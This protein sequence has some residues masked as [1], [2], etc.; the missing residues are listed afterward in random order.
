MHALCSKRDRFFGKKIL[1]KRR[2]FFTNKRLTAFSDATRLYSRPHIGLLTG[3][4]HVSTIEDVSL[5]ACVHGFTA[6]APPGR[7]CIV[8]ILWSS[9]GW[10]YDGWRERERERERKGG[11]G[12]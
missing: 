4:Y 9:E 11:G 7:E 2:L 3:P 10:T 8:A 12:E 6:I 5:I 1:I